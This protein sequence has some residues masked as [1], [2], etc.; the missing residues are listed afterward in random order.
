[1]WY[2]SLLQASHLLSLL[3][4]AKM[5][6]KPATGAHPLL[7]SGFLENRLMMA[8]VSYNQQHAENGHIRILLWALLSPYM[9]PFLESQGDN[10]S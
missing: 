2:L 3:G 1:M 10:H 7:R 4:P 6:L 8:H 5:S 9:D